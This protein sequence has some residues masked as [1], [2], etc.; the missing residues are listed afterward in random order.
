[1]SWWPMGRQSRPQRAAHGVVLRLGLELH[2]N[3]V[4]VPQEM[5]HAVR[6]PRRV[7]H[8]VAPVAPELRQAEPG[9]EASMPTALL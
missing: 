5:P 1:L 9:A 2:H 6:V 7:P 8:A 3:E 4:R